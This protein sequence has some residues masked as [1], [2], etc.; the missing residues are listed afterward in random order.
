[1]K[2]I[3]R[4]TESD[5]T[6]IVKRVIKEQEQQTSNDI[7]QQVS[8]L[9]PSLSVND[10]A[11]PS[12][13]YVPKLTGDVKKDNIIKQAYKWAKG[14]TLQSLFGELKNL[15]QKRKEAKELEKR[16]EL[17]EQVV[18]FVV[19]GVSVSASLLIAIGAILLFI[20]IIAIISKKGGR[21][22]GRSCNPGLWDRL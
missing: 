12:C 19:L 14:Q 3:V 18:A 15:K 13:P 16:G 6:R 7:Q 4:L 2:K 17:N 20:I 10:L 8:E 5:L 1:M 22:R 9:D 21:K 11:D